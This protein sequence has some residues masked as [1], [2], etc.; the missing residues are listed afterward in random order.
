MLKATTD[1][2]LSDFIGHLGGQ[3]PSDDLKNLRQNMK[4]LNS[5]QLPQLQAGLSKN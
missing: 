4:T 2:S 3:L 5:I 1:S